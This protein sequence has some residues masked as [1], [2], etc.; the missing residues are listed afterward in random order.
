MSGKLREY[1]DQVYADDP[2]K[3]VRFVNRT[4]RLVKIGRHWWRGYRKMVDG[5]VTVGGA[6]VVDDAVTKPAWKLLPKAV[7]LEFSAF[8]RAVDDVIAGMC[9]TRS[10]RTDEAGGEPLVFG[11]GVYAIDV[12]LWPKAATMLKQLQAKW[13]ESADRYC[14]QDGYAQFLEA[15]KE[16]VGADRFEGV[17][18]MVPPAEVLR[19][20][21]WLE[22]TPLT[23]RLTEDVSDPDE[24][25]GRATAFTELVEAAVK[26]PR[27]AA[28]E[29]WR[30]L[31]EQMVVPGP[32]PVPYRPT[33][34]QPDGT[35][36]TVSRGVRWGS[37][38]GA[39]RALETVNRSTRFHD[40]VLVMALGALAREVTADRAAATV[41]AGNVN[42]HDA[43]AVRIGRCLLDAA[44][45]AAD[46]DNMCIGVGQAM[47]TGGL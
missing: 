43:E 15:V 40:P 45:A 19:G 5:K 7:A 1:I 35:L 34:K 16:H 24:D 46:E 41:I 22:V 21:F 29:V 28:A 42:A 33:R 31:A 25:R 26:G 27:E 37:V 23:F 47:S 44:D 9:V 18:H 12:A 17:R 11:G 30:G 6:D 10:A 14:T 4:V 13:A 39:A 38:A 32:T 8:E 3:A 36:R 20:R 2:S